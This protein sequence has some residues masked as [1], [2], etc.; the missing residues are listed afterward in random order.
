[1]HARAHAELDAPWGRSADWA[2][3]VSTSMYDCAP[4]GRRNGEPVADCF[5]VLGYPE[6]AVI[7]V[8]DGVNWGEPPRRCGRAGQGQ[9]PVPFRT[10][11]AM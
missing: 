2:Y 1:M 7:A 4:S 8:A 10:C 9:P 6:G 11:N 3:G 5:G